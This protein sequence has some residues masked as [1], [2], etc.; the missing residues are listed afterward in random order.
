MLHKECLT[1]IKQQKIAPGC[2]DK[3][4]TSEDIVKAYP[5]G[6]NKYVILEDKELKALKNEHDIKSINRNGILI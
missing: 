1:P 2:D 4:V 3:E 5:Y 6:Y